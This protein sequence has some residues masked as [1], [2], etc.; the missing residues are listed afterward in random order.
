MIDVQ[1]TP[2]IQ[3][4]IELQSLNQQQKIW[5]ILFFIPLKLS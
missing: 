2:N 5:V 4:K 1:V 3:V